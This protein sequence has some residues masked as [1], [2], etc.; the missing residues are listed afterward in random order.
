MSV[1]SLISGYFFAGIYRL[2][3]MAVYDL[4]DPLKGDCLNEDI[5]F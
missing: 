4:N 2:I 5:H 3:L 1:K